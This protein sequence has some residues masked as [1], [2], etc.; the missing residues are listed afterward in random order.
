MKEGG[1]LS[2][3]RA[4]RSSKLKQGH[5]N[6]SRNSQGVPVR[7]PL[8]KQPALTWSDKGKELASSNHTPSNQ[9]RDK[10]EKA[11]ATYARMAVNNGKH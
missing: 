11:K 4:A 5:T 1:T 9:I 10:Q 8:H 7:V 3:R 6:L 2:E